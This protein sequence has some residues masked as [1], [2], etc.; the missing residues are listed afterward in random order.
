[1]DGE[2]SN[3]SNGNQVKYLLGGILIGAAVGSAVALLYAPMKGEDTRRLLKEK[4]IQGKQYAAEKANQVKE[5]ATAAKNR[6]S[7]IL[8]CVKSQGA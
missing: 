1:M 7:E 5:M 2:T 4:A 3:S 8:D 6:G